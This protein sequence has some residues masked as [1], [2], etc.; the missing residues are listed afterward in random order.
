MPIL[1]I[2]VLAF[3]LPA[4]LAYVLTSS[5]IKSF[6]VSVGTFLLFYLVFC[7]FLCRSHL[8]V[9]FG[10][11]GYSFISF[12]GIPYVLL[13]LSGAAVGSVL[14]YGFKR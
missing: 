11:I 9:L 14:K 3:I 5:G 8:D 7:L 2:A 6:L 4:V 12:F 1:I 13:V 10:C